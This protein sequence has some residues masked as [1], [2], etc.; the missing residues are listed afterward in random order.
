VDTLLFGDAADRCGSVGR[1]RR[2]EAGR[3]E[4]EPK[5]QQGVRFVFDDHDAW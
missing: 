2:F 1:K 3:V 4:V 5:H